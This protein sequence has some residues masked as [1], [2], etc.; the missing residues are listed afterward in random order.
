M[1]QR[2]AT[3]VAYYVFDV[4]QVDGTDTIALPYEQRRALLAQLIEPGSHWMV[5]AHRVGDGAALLAATAERGLEGVMAKRLGAPYLPGTRSP[6]WRKVK[7]RRRLEVVI[8]GFTRGEGNRAGTFG[9]LLV[10]LP[11]T[12]GSLRFAGGVGTGFDQARLESLTRRL[13]DLATADCP[14]AT[15]P[16]RSHALHATWVRPELRAVVE[17]AELTNDG[18]VR[19]ASF[20]D[21]A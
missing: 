15:A 11:E 6:A 13:R 20:V 18:L 10:G 14:F 1:L 7:V 9:A 17:I 5:P 4:L 8:G 19:H 16:P 21:L 2:H 12:D 3:E